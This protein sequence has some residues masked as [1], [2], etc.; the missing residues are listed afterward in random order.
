MF[1]IFSVCTLDKP[2]IIIMFIVRKL[3]HNSDF[4]K[5]FVLCSRVA[6][7]FANDRWELERMEKNPNNKIDETGK[8]F[9]QVILI[10]RVAA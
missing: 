9:P 4:Q 10:S 7:S 6:F 5:G 3:S 2:L 8:T 1:T